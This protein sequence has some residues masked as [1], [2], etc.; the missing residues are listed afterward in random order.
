[1]RSWWQLQSHPSLQF[2]LSAN[3]MQTLT[4]NRTYY[5][6]TDGND[7]NSGTENTAAGAFLTVQ[8]A[9]DVVASQLIVPRGI[10]VTIQIADGTY[11]A[12]PKAYFF[13]GGGS[14]TIAGNAGTPANVVLTGELQIFAQSVTVQ[15]FTITGTNA[16]SARFGGS[17]T[18]GAG[19]IFG[20][21]TDTTLL[22]IDGGLVIITSAY[23]VTGGGINHLQARRGGIVRLFANV[24]FSA[25]HAFSSYIA[26]AFMGGLIESSAVVFTGSPTG[27]RYLSDSL[28]IIHTSGGGAS[29]FP[30][31][32]AGA[33]ANSGIYV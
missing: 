28:S 15:N 25:A 16:I 26:Y 22:A 12:T 24:T 13:L 21:V 31:T 27:Q 2:F 4:A 33:V 1:M 18:I 32:I 11:V 20:A 6:R 7:G 10:T 14:L 23:T 19:M 29:Y 5:V 9:L 30:G 17:V 8:K 3:N